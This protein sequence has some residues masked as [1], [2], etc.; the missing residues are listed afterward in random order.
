MIQGKVI[1]GEGRGHAL[2]IPTLNVETVGVDLAYGVYAVWVYWQDLRLPGV[3]NWG[4]R[5]TFHEEE[6]R[7]EVHLLEGGDDFYGEEVRVEVVE[8]LRGV[9]S[10]ASKEE[11]IAQIQKDI[12]GARNRLVSTR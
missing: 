4:S 9:Q 10:F 12:E 3:M 8:R 7:L 2:G 1:H 5:P 11:L 6:P